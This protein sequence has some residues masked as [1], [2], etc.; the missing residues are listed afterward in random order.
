MTS[1]CRAIAAAAVSLVLMASHTSATLAQSEEE[2]VKALVGEWEV[3]DDTYAL[4]GKNCHITLGET[5]T[6]ADYSLTVK[7]CELELGMLT[8]WR[9][10]SGQLML[11]ADGVAVAALGGNEQRMSGDSNIGAPIILDRAGRPGLMDR[12]LK[13]REASGCYY[14]GFSKTCIDEAQLAKPAVSPDGSAASIGVLVNLNVR[15]EARDSADVVGVVP[16]NSCVVV[17]VCT[18]ASDGVWCR[19]RFG[20]TGGWLKKLALRQ[21]RWPVV[22]FVNQCEAK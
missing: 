2:F 21:E 13:A 16:A 17:E 4:D 12:I 9:I 8:S 19:A 10:V 7:S 6:E 22:T 14:L 18:T 1:I 15:E 20:E 11:M 5:K 3:V